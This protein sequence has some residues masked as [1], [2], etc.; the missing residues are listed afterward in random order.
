[1]S[2]ATGQS[3]PL[4]P[5]F[6][7]VRKGLKLPV[8]HRR[9]RVK[10]PLR[11]SSPYRVVTVKRSL[12]SPVVFDCPSAPLTWNG[13]AYHGLLVVRRAGKRVS[14][15]N[16][17]ALD[18]YV[19][20]VVGGEMPHRWRIAALAAQAVASRSYA[21]S[22]LTSNRRFD[23]YADTR[24]QVYGG[25]AYETPQTNEAVRRTAGRVLMWNGHVALTYFFST[26]G[27]RTADVREVWPGG[28]DVPYL[29]S[30]PDPYDT[31][32]PHHSWGPIVFGGDRVAKLLKARVRGD[33]ELERTASG[34]V[35]T[36][37]IGGKRIDGDRVRQAL[38]LQSTW[39]DVGELTLDSSRARVVFGGTLQLLAR[40]R[41]AGTAKLQRR[42]GA[43]PWRT[44]KTVYTGARVD[45]Q[46]RGRTLY[47]LSAD[48]V[49]GPVVSVDVAPQLEVTPAAETMLAG[50]VAPRS[51][52]AITVWREIA[53]A[54]RIVARPHLDANG[55]F[56]A[57]VRLHP[58]GYR[59]TVGADARFAE[60][61]TKIRVTQRL[62]ASLRDS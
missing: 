27:G 46:P 62:L 17:L 43:G 51:H 38:G 57:P 10:H 58:G 24:S 45:L 23:L 19:R 32:S 15:V 22:H 20:G 3:W 55:T 1:V 35:K 12:R 34:R 54:W 2:D 25:I 16:S 52:G 9:V 48:G 14:V 47:R 33:V 31:Q 6:Y 4:P 36:V 44:L 50:T 28:A 40:T 26:S 39:F 30:V 11:R 7:R 61:T 5:G 56:R 42:V 59:I 29:R 18:D 13:R 41:H 53:G 8:G 37:V 21:L 49:K 60:A